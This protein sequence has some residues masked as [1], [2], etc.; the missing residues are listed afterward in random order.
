MPRIEP[1]PA[2]DIDIGRRLDKARRSML[3]PRAALAGK[4]GISADRLVS[5][6]FGRAKLPWGVGER[7]CSVF[8]INPFWLY[9]GDGPLWF[10][11]ALDWDR[12]KI[13]ARM[14]FS[15]AI[16]LAVKEDSGIRSFVTGVHADFPINEPP[17]GPFLNDLQNSVVAEIAWNHMVSWLDQIGPRDALTFAADLVRAGNELI[18]VYARKKQGR[19]LKQIARPGIASVTPSHSG[20]GNAENANSPGGAMGGHGVRIVFHCDASGHSTVLDALEKVARPRLWRAKVVR[21][22][23]GLERM[24]D[25]PRTSI[26]KRPESDA[27]RTVSVYGWSFL[28]LQTSPGELRI[29]QLI[30]DAKAVPARSGID[31]TAAG[32][33]VAQIH[34]KFSRDASYRKAYVEVGD[35]VLFALHCRALRER[36][37]MTQAELGHKVDLSAAEIGRF[38]QGDETRP[39]IV[40]A[41]IRP[42]ADELRALGLDPAARLAAAKAA[43]LEKDSSLSTMSG[44]GNR[45]LSPVTQPIRAVPMDEGALTSGEH[46][47][48]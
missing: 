4:V 46:S 31:T 30:S 48:V 26:R 17:R 39:E 7:I 6:E 13:P 23:E 45:R 19:H 40:G 3:I 21:M 12:F 27:L 14:P 24:I 2:R 9:D 28:A 36:A 43:P 38:E 20:R 25:P 33:A 18:S 10:G 47:P 44:R 11:G 15:E 32:I 16:E 8:R 41:I 34:E 1:L 29:I 22:L 5:Y 35:L 42:F 37:G